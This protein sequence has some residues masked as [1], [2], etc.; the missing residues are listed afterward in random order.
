MLWILGLIMKPLQ[1][2]RDEISKKHADTQ[3]AIQTKEKEIE[4]L[5][6][7]I[8]ELK[9]LKEFYSKALQNEI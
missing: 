3:W 4:K 5:K 7:E 1:K 6:Q 2:E 8:K 9:D